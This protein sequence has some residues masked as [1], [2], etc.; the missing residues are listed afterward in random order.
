MTTPDIT[1]IA[2]GLTSGAKAALMSGAGCD[3]HAELVDAGLWTPEPGYGHPY[4]NLTTL[5]TAVRAALA[6]ENGTAPDH[7][8]GE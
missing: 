5:G 2:R 1:A 4:Y 7:K 6:K 8:A 3:N